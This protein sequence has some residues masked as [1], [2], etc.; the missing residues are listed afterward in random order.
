MGFIGLGGRARWILKN[1]AL[2]G[3]EVV[4]IAD[5]FLPRLDEAASQVAGANRS[6]PPRRPAAR[7]TAAHGQLEEGSAGAVGR[8][9]R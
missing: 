6:S 5:C 2:P 4:A 7:P 1:E 3:A 8:A 9:G